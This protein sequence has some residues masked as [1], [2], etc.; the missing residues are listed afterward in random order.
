MIKNDI[1]S[2]PIK[3]LWLSRKATICR[4]LNIFIYFL[5]FAFIYFVCSR[6]QTFMYSKNLTIFSF[7][8]VSVTGLSFSSTLILAARNIFKIKELAT[9]Y[10]FK[11]SAYY[12][13]VGPFV[14]TALIWAL[15]GIVSVI[16]GAFCLPNY[17]IRFVLSLNI[18]LSCLGIV[19]LCSLLVTNIQE[20]SKA[21]GREIKKEMR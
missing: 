15:L 8:V 10:E 2:S 3:I 4:T 11:P 7:F 18:V 20:L 5:G 17:V 9:I 19:N 12:N 16:C 6:P 1:E 21:T 14:F 13:F